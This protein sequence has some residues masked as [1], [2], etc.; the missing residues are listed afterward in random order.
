MSA[1]VFVN[2]TNIRTDFLVNVNNH[3]GLLT[4]MRWYTV[5]WNMYS[6][7]I[8]YRTRIISNKTTISMTKILKKKT[9]SRKCGSRNRK[10]LNV[11][12]VVW[13]VNYSRLL[14]GSNNLQEVVN[15]SVFG[16]R[17]K[18]L[19]TSARK[20]SIRNYVRIVV[21]RVRRVRSARHVTFE[22]RSC[23]SFAVA[24]VFV[25]I[26]FRIHSNNSAVMGKRK[27]I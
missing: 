20:F 27:Y 24:L 21:Y 16:F 7:T 26:C 23:A 3:R 1:S 19:Q 14:F 18:L 4:V 9:D 15:R 12:K 25:R 6:S 11:P 2:Y 17:L 5:T 10:K 8:V 13:V 22:I